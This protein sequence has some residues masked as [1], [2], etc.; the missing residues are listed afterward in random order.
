MPE[1]L[2]GGRQHAE[3][4]EV[5]RRVRSRWRTK[6]LLRGGI[7]IVGGALL[8]LLLASLGLQV[9]KFSALSIVGFRV[10]TL[11]V[12]ALLVA[13]WFVRPLRRRVSDMQVALFVEEHEPSLQAAILSAVEVG[14]TGRMGDQ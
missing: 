5:I 1:M 4:V 12:F 11:V 14:T 7:V 8:A 3:L 2:S 13:L 10:L 6:L 9:L